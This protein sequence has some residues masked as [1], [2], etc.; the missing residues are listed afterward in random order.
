MSGPGISS[1]SRAESEGRRLRRRGARPAGTAKLGWSA[2]LTLVLA[3]PGCAGIVASSGNGAD[4]PCA[5]PKP[6]FAGENSERQQETLEALRKE[7][8]RTVTE[9][10]EFLRRY[11]AEHG[12]NS[13]EIK[14]TRDERVARRLEQGYD[15]KDEGSIG[16]LV[17]EVTAEMRREYASACGEVTNA[18]R[19]LGEY[20]AAE[21]A[22]ILLDFISWSDPSDPAAAFDF[23]H[24]PYQWC[25]LVNIG[26]PVVEEIARRAEGE[27]EPWQQANYAYLVADILKEDAAAWFEG[28]LRRPKLTARARENLRAMRE[29]LI[30]CGRLPA[31][32]PEANAAGGK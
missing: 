24:K 18:I 9:L 10:A 2:A 26:Q 8:S 13:P 16:R 27:L 20:R 1:P 19:L 29:H 30:K 15:W 25:A 11:K 32:S 28:R 5:A 23:T 17:S 7:R 6:L 12:M 14:P 3:A 31:P 21:A 22:G 4:V